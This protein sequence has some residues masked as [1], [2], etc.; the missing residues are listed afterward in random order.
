MKIAKESSLM[1][2]N[3][4]LISIHPIYVERILSGEKRFEFRRS[5]AALPVDFLVI[6]ATSPVQRIVALAKIGRTIRGNKTRLWAIARRK[7]AG[8][9]RNK[10]FTYLYG[11]KEGVAL[12]L[13]R[14]LKLTEEVDPRMIFG[15]N[16]SPPQSFRYLE[17]NELTLLTKHLR[18]EAWE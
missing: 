4:A 2:S 18:Y 10:L 7:G 8:I 13:V 11:K 12:E 16:F 3:A 17:Q 9:S 6:Y 5:W 1:A 15:K 14:R